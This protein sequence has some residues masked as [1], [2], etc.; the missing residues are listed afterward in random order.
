VINRG[1]I[2]QADAIDSS[3][4]VVLDMDNNEIPVYG[5]QEHSAYSWYFKFTSYPPLQLFNQEGNCLAAKLRLGKVPSAGGRRGLLFPEI[6]RQH[7]K[8]KEGVFR[9]CNNG[10]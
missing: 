8:E 4:R 6:K 7:R 3:P 9:G 10:R 1:R 2:A 5:Q